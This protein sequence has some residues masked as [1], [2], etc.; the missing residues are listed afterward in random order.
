M[1]GAAKHV[2]L[3]TGTP[4]GKDKGALMLAE[5]TKAIKERVD[6]PLHIQLEP[7]ENTGLLETLHDADVDTVG[8]HIESFDPKVS[9]R[10]CPAKER[11]KDY[12]KAWKTAVKLFGEGQVSTF[13]LA[14]LGETDESI[15][16]GAEKAAEIGVV[17]Y[18]VPLRPIPGTI[19]ENASPPMPARM[20]KLY[21]SVAETL[22]KVGLDPGRSKAGCV[23]CGA[24]SALQEVFRNLK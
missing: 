24:C 5:A 21:L 8:L 4:Q 6:I 23:R 22:H 9:S 19:F 2:T 11:M 15:T 1:E 12:V 7:P 18:L 13:I 10:I 14:G 17:P 20:M 16:L 3:T